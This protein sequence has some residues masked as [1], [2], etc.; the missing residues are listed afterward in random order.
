[1]PEPFAY[2]EL[3]KQQLG[4]YLIELG[5][6]STPQGPSPYSIVHMK[7]FACCA[8]SVGGKLA[9]VRQFRY[10]VGSWQLELPAGGIEAGELPREAAVR[11]LREETGLVACDVRDLGMVYPSVGSTDEQCHV[12]A[13]RCEDALVRRELDRGEQTELLLLSR[14]EVER[15]MAEGSLVYPPLFV[16]WLKLERM[17]MLDE[18]FPWSA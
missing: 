14:E 17:G 6:L 7:P 8:A 12:F 18:L 1:M 3:E 10:S 4:R 11:E 2:H 5:E 13:C 16:A 9:M 15:M